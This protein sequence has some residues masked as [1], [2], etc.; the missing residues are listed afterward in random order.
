VTRWQ[1]GWRGMRR[2]RHAEEVDAG[3][4][5]P[6]VLVNEKGEHLAAFQ[7]PE[8]TASARIVLGSEAETVPR[9]F[10]P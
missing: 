9:F 8:Q 3:A 2:S 7:D 6:R 4:L 5:A 10:A 1:Q